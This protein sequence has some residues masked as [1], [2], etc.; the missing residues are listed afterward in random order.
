MPTEITKIHKNGTIDISV[1][2]EC[3]SPITHATISGMHCSNPEC[4]LEKQNNKIDKVLRPLL[5]K[6]S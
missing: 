6:L 1:T 5:D 4:N 3:G 2:C